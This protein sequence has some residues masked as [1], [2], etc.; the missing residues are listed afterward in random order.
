MC[1]LYAGEAG[2]AGSLGVRHGWS[3][4][5]TA[6]PFPFPANSCQ[7][8]VRHAPEFLPTPAEPSQGP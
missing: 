6:P 3:H 7:E 1:S 8:N 2:L 4:A 5:E